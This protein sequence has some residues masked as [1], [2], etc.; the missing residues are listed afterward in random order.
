ME[1]WIELGRQKLR[2]IFGNASEDLT[3]YSSEISRNIPEYRRRSE[4]ILRDARNLEELYTEADSLDSLRE[5][6][7]IPLFGMIE[8]LGFSITSLIEFRGSVKSLLPL[9]A[10][11]RSAKK[12]V[13]GALSDLIEIQEDFLVGI[14]NLTIT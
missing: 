3:V 10:S 8:K 11:I 6:L 5:Q 7:G 1:I 13:I 12:A 4:N 2:V 9:T 14:E